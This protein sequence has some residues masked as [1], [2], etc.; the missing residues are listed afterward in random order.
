MK[1]LVVF[2]IKYYSIIFTVEWGKYV[3]INGDFPVDLKYYVLIL[4]AIVGNN[5]L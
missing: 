3:P 5:Y 1:Q 2:L 4:Q